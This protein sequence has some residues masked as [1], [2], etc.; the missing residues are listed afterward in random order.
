[1]AECVVDEKILSSMNRVVTQLMLK[2]WKSPALVAVMKMTTQQKRRIT[3]KKVI[4]LVIV[5]MKYV[6]ILMQFHRNSYYMEK[7]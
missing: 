1:M 5:K 7:T 4:N 6:N 3:R 2:K